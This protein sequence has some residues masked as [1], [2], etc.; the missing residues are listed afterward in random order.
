VTHQLA[1]RPPQADLVTILAASLPPGSAVEATLVT[2]CFLPCIQIQGSVG[3]ERPARARAAVLEALSQGL[4]VRLEDGSTGEAGIDSRKLLDQ[5]LEECCKPPLCCWCC[6]S[7]IIAA[8]T[9]HRAHHTI[10]CSLHA[11]Y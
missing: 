1:C 3:N 4:H 2:D 7:D 11:A 5:L 8:V 10:P 6:R 9:M